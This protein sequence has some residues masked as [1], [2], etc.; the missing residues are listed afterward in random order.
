M[1]KN[2]TLEHFYKKKPV[3]EIEFSVAKKK[4]VDILTTKTDNSAYIKW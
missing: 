1:N 4:Y 2:G 3:K